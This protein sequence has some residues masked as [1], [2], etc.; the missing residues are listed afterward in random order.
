[1]LTEKTAISG[2]RKNEDLRTRSKDRWVLI[3]DSAS[4]KGVIHGIVEVLQGYVE[5]PL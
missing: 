3:Y 4:F 2:Q 5:A 1:V